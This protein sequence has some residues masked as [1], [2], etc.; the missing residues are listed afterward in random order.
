MEKKHTK[1]W[2][3]SIDDHDFSELNKSY[4]KHTME[5]ILS[6][7]SNVMDNAR[8]K[9]NRIPLSQ[10]SPWYY[11]SAIG[12]IRNERGSFF[13]IT[14]IRV[15]QKEEMIEEQPIILQPEIGF[16][17]IISCKINGVWHYLMQAKI[18]PG[19][20][21]VVQLSPTIQAT[22]SNF[23]QKHGGKKPQYLDY[24]LNMSADEILVDQLQSEQSSRFMKKRNRNVIIML[25]EELEETETH[26]WLTL[27]QIKK[28][29][30]FDNLINMDTRTVLSCIP[31]VLLGQEADVPFHS[32]SYFFNT[33]TNMDRK[34]IASLYTIIND[35]KM[36]QKRKIEQ[37]P[38]H[39]LTQW[40]M[41]D[42]SIVCKH[43]YPF[44]VIYCDVT[45]QGREVNHW[46]QPLIASNGV[47]L[48]GL[49]CCDFH[50]ILKFLVKPRAE[51]G[52]LDSIEIGPTLQ[53]EPYKQIEDSTELYNLF[54]QKLEKK[55][56]IIADIM[57]SEEGGRFYQE[58]NRNVIIKIHSSELNFPLKEYVWADYGTLN[59]LTQVN[60]CLSIQLRNLLSLM[61]F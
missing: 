48:L 35:Y 23:E 51:M 54:S 17:G 7:L 16:L 52:C 24:F 20:V 1:K 29:M 10:C 37:V 42:Y 31:Y 19:N 41:N 60:N 26:R 8:V 50:G 9:L 40:E 53:I 28:L 59:L 58:Q 45:I 5:E 4:A 57:L 55:Q 11:D 18:E 30:H 44:S 12:Q 3:P 21:N 43:N 56:D 2:I 61:E 15:M 49:V 46:S 47:T 25:N 33:A 34:T 6:W 38:L 39:A 22:K 13:S 14:G 36:F 27:K 32:Q